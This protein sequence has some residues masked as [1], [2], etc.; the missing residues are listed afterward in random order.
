M[1]T[2]LQGIV[3]TNEATIKTNDGKDVVPA[4]GFFTNVIGSVV[5]KAMDKS[6]LSKEERIEMNGFRLKPP[7][8]PNELPRS[9]E[10]PSFST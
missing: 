8:E 4:L 10:P 6:D 5:T 7:K 2:L 1:E 9:Y 3:R